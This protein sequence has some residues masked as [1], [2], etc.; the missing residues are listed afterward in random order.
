LGG[1]WSRHWSGLQDCK[2]LTEVHLS[3]FDGTISGL[4]NVNELQKITLIQPNC[5]SLEGIGNAGKLSDFEVALAK[6]LESI[7]EL[8]KL[9]N[10]LV[11]LSIDG[12]RSIRSYNAVG[13][14]AGLMELSI[15]DSAA[16]DS[17]SILE[18]M[19]ALRSLRVVGTKINN[20]DLTPCIQ[21]ASL[22]E[23]RCERRSGYKPS[24]NEVIETLRSR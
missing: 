19:T 6:R 22:K 21:N 3:G 4:P 23:F 2:A 13:S 8:D 12:C 7:D 24:V 14:L 11:S 9:A 5:T 16:L 10:T 20:R 17:L 15:L 1:I 18:R